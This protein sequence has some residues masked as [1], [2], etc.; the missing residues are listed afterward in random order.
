LLL[1]FFTLPSNG[2]ET[3]HRLLRFWTDDEQL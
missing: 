1:V 3:I 2:R